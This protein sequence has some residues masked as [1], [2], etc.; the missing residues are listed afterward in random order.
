MK[1]SVVTPSFNQGKY[2]LEAIESVNVQNYCS[3]EH[4]IQDNC[5]VDATRHIIK[6]YSHLWVATEEDEGQSDALNRGFKKAT[7]D[8]IGWLNADDKYLPGCFKAVVNFFIKNPQCDVL[9]GD[10]R[11]I[12]NKSKL[13]KLRKEIPFDLFILKYLHVLCIPSTATFF[14]RRI[15][16]E[17]NFLDKRYHYAMDYEFFLRLALKGYCFAH[18]PA[19]LAD[20]R[21]HDASKSSQFEIVQRQEREQALLELDKSWHDLRSPWKPFIRG[22][23]LFAARFKRTILQLIGSC[24]F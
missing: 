5:S 14:R 12:D 16:E 9:Y 20:F 8:I 1:I 15:F 11:I 21:V 17:G 24:Y 3:F 19:F 7:G 13:I 6:Q 23:L 10:Y 22:S 2:I 4:I 18:I